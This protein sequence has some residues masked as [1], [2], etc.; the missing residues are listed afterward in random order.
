MPQIKKV[1]LSTV[2]DS[3]SDE[4]IAQ[5]RRNPWGVKKKG[6]RTS[7]F[8]RYSPIKGGSW[9]TPRSRPL[10]VSRATYGGFSTGSLA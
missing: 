6:P 10:F 2:T 3:M 5:K 1:D 8:T 9:F 4:G 7:L